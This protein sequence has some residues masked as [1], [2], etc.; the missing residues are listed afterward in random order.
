MVLI[1]FSRLIRDSAPHINT[2]VI[3]GCLVMLFGCYVLGIDSSNPPRPSDTEFVGQ[4]EEAVPKEVL[5]ARD[6]RYKVICTVRACNSISVVVENFGGYD[7]CR[8]ATYIYV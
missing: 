7:F 6:Y 1:L 3:I 5:D 8:K 4:L 2:T